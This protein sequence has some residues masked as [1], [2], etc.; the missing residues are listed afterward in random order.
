MYI[1]LG[2]SRHG[3]WHTYFVLFI[4]ML[5]GGL[6]HGASWMFV[7]WGAFHGAY[8]AIE[9]MTKASISENFISKRGKSAFIFLIVSLTW[10]FFRSESPTTA[11][12]IFQGLVNTSE[13]DV[14]GRSEL[15]A[16]ISIFTML[17]W[18]FSMKNRSTIELFQKLG[19][20]L[21]SL[22]LAFV[23]VSLFLCSGGNPSAFIYF[24]F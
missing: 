5:I 22:L 19:T 3:N 6:W 24:Q 2:G 11:F 1:P 10:I 13:F 16:V 14:I 17:L 9:R 18:H 7:L 15:I 12:Y 20:T 23:L 4:T 8:L 21:Q